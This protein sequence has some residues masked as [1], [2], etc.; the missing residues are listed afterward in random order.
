MSDCTVFHYTCDQYTPFFS[1]SH[2]IAINSAIS[3]PQVVKQSLK[4][5]RQ[6]KSNTLGQCLY[7]YTP[8]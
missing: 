2:L 8:F 1:S 4:A 5:Q 7:K 3:K 6:H